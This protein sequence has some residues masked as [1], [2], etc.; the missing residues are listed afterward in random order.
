MDAS[1]DEARAETPG[2]CYNISFQKFTVAVVTLSV[3][4]IRE[5]VL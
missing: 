4:V 5:P 3:F 2:C 1:N